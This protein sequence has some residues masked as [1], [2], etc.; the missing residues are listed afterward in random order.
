MRRG[1]GLER[2]AW[3]NIESSVVL[4]KL[5]VLMKALTT[6]LCLPISDQSCAGKRK[7]AMNPLSPNWC[8]VVSL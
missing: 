3:F 4:W 7:D 6:S 5:T 1:R 8:S 2:L